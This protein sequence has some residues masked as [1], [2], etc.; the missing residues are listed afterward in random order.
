LFPVDH[1]DSVH[2][3][4]ETMAKN[5]LARPRFRNIQEFL[6]MKS[7]FYINGPVLHIL[8]HIPLVLESYELME[9]S[10]FPVNIGN[11]LWTIHPE[12]PSYFLVNGLR[13]L[14]VPMEVIQSC[15]HINRQFW[16]HQLPSLR[17]KFEDS[18][19]G[20]LYSGNQQAISKNCALSPFRQP[21][22][23]VQIRDKVMIFSNHSQQ[24]TLECPGSD[25]QR[26]RISGVHSLQVQQGCR[27]ISASMELIISN[28]ILAETHFNLQLSTWRAPE[29]LK[30]EEHIRTQGSRIKVGTPIEKTLEDIEHHQ[31]MIRD[32]KMK[33]H[34]LLIMFIFILITISLIIMFLYCKFRHVHILSHSELVALKT[35]THQ[36][37]EIND[38]VK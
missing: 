13:H 23:M 30:L 2:Q 19:M 7:S 11:N 24:I 9:L 1:F 15:S 16:C 14:E 33:D 21:E 34:I 37:N 22:M 36:D 38:S 25:K 5:S 27:V 20:S 10:S 32:H 26:V 17:R 35:K 29:M 4:I 6:Q 12:T 8:V 18:C 28:D 31:L 3:N